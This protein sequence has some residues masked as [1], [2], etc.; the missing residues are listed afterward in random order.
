LSDGVDYDKRC[1]K[2][3][4]RITRNCCVYHLGYFKNRDDAVA[5]RR[6]AERK[7]NKGKRFKY[8]HSYSTTT[9]PVEVE[10]DPYLYF[11]SFMTQKSIE[12]P[13]RNLRLAVLIQAVKD[14]LTDRNKNTQKSARL[15]FAGK[16]ESEPTFSFKEII[17]MF[18][19]TEDEVRRYLKKASK[20]KKQALRS[21][22]RRLVRAHSTESE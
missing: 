18:G 10:D 8:L 19:I 1:K 7:Y 5:A 20:N 21:M 4:A 9:A 14:Y 12:D 11:V 3:R 16:I 2:F 13:H 22:G 6:E 17:E 15:W